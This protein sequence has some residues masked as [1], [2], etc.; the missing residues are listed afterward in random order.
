M[1]SCGWSTTTPRDGT[2]IMNIT[3]RIGRNARRAV[4]VTGAAALIAGLGLVAMA[5]GAVANGPGDQVCSG[6]DSGKRDVAGEPGSLTISAPDGQLIDGYCVKAGS[7]NQEGGGPVYVDVTPPE[8][9]VTISHPSGKG[10]SHYSASYTTPPATTTSTPPATTTTT[11]PSTTTTTTPPSTTTTTH[12]PSTTTTT[13]PPSTTTTTST[14]P[15]T[16]T[17][18]STPPATTTTTSTP[19]ATTT[20]PPGNPNEDC[21]D[22]TTTLAKY[23]W[24]GSAWVAEFGGDIV[25]S[26]T[27]DATSATFT[28]AP[29][30][31]VTVVVVKASIDVKFDEDGNLS[32]DNTGLTNP[33]GQVPDISNVQFCGDDVPTTTTTTPGTTTTTTPG[34]TTTTTPGTT[35]TTTPGT[36]TTTPGTTTTTTP[37]TTT[38]T[39]PGT[40]TTTT[41]GTTTTTTPGTTT[42]PATPGASIVPSTTPPPSAAPSVRAQALARTGAELWTAAGLAGLLL[43]GG[44]AMVALG[45]GSPRGRRQ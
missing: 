28:V 4:T 19:P 36:T 5:P 21:P 17:T 22:G 23:E 27:G 33:G 30:Y 13:H 45:T 38:T 25:T 20:T 43:L 9:S 7:G 32:F 26:V 15:A 12:P 2:D 35:T 11:P 29:G 39:T 3:L 31:V 42:T 14:P 37:G 34:T 6:L 8:E 1:A 41:P 24:N 44:G 16:T 18:T 10:I 40:T